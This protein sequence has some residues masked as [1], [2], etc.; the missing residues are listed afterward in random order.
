[1][2]SYNIHRRNPPTRCGG[3]LWNDAKMAR[4]VFAKLEHVDAFSIATR[5]SGLYCYI[6]ADDGRTYHV[7]DAGQVRQ[8]ARMTR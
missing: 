4:I 8:E 6:V 3:D 5:S 2:I 7:T 1:M